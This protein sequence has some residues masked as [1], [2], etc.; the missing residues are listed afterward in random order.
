MLYSFKIDIWPPWWVSVPPVLHGDVILHHMDITKNEGS[1]EGVDIQKRCRCMDVNP[2]Q[3]LRTAIRAMDRG[4]TSYL[5]T[6]LN[7]R[8][9][10]Y[11]SIY[12]RPLFGGT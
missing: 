4:P 6:C 1:R 10:C 2:G 11:I 7:P 5:P 8:L 3:T 9:Y 12:R